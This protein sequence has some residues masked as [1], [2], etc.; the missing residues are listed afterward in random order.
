MKKHKYSL[1]NKTNKK[2]DKQTRE[3]DILTS[4]DLQK[5]IFGEQF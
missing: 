1:A 5:Y 2:E 4:A 3:F